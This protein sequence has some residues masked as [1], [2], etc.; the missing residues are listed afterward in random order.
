MRKVSLLFCCA[1]MM[2][3]SLSARTSSGKEAGI[4]SRYGQLKVVKS[5]LCDSNGNPVCLRGVSSHGLQWNPFQKGTITN[6]VK[7]WKITV[8]R[9][10]MYTD[11]NGYI[12]NPAMMKERLKL[13][14]D[15]AIEND[16]YVLIDWHILRENDPNKYRKESIAFFTEMAKTYGNLPNVIYEICNEPNGSNVSWLEQVSPYANTLIAS[17]RAIDPDN[18]IIVGTDNFCQ[19]VEI[20]SEL[21]LKGNNIMYALHFYAGSHGETLRDAA[22]SALEKGLPLFVSECGLTDA[23]GDTGTNL[24]EAKAWFDWMNDK[25]ISWIVWSFSAHHEGSAM[26]VPGTELAGPWSDAQITSNGRWVK[27]KIS[28]SSPR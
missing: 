19:G 18:I 23:A 2:A 26:L 1:V 7:E 5:Q 4:V 11:E 28:E 21:P 3:L 25:K 14:V 13:I 20:A 6:L 16:I 15:E 22:D 27:K 24:E 12:A 9:A 10:A 8:V 17:I